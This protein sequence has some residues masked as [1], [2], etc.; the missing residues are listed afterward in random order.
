MGLITLIF[1]L[2]LVFSVFA[3]KRGCHV[4]LVSD[5]SGNKPLWG[6][7]TND[8]GGSSIRTLSQTSGL[9]LNKLIALQP[10][11]APDFSSLQQRNISDFLLLNPFWNH[12]ANVIMQGLN[13][14]YLIIYQFIFEIR[15]LFY[16]FC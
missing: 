1:Q 10:C 7:V 15:I 3:D 14:K 6:I 5:G 13:Y 4:A 2:A 16:F 9:T 12:E 8:K 11:L